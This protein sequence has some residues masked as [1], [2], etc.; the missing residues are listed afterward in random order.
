[1]LRFVARF[2]GIWLFAGSIV[3]A[4]LDGAR[5]VA[6][7]RLVFTSVRESWGRWSPG[8]LASLEAT[9]ERTAIPSVNDFIAAWLLG[10]PSWVLLGAIAFLLVAI[11]RRRRL[12]PYHYEFTA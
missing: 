7:S 9:L 12:A 8:T 5:S 10:A 11:G 1:M 4:V 3:L 2:T 6:A